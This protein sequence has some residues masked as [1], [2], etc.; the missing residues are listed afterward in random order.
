[1]NHLPIHGS[2]AVLIDLVPFSHVNK[3]RLL[4]QGFIYLFYNSLE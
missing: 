1:M 3:T 2:P 4:S